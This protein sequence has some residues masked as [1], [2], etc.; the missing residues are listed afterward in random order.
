M[1]NP[2]PVFVFVHVI[3][4]LRLAQRNEPTTVSVL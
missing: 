3:P 4:S 1:K 2:W